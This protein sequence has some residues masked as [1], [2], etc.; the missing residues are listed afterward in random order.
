M[1]ELIKA[2]SANLH[3][4]SVTFQKRTYT[5]Q[6]SKSRILSALH[7]NSK[8][9]NYEEIVSATGVLL[10]TVKRSLRGLKAD[11]L[12]DYTVNASKEREY[13]ISL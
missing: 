13:K 6:N 11:G 1:N 5:G 8:P 7:Q 9:L 4:S 2:S 3:T 12:V 10:E